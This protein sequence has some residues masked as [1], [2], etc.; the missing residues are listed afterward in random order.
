[1]YVRNL[2]RWLHKSKITSLFF[3]LDI[4]KA[5][6]SVKWDY[7]L[8]ILQ[9]RGFPC[10]FTDWI[11]TLLC[12]STSRIL[13]N[14]VVELP[15]SMVEAFAKGTPFPLLFKI[16]VDPLQQILELEHERCFFTRFAGGVP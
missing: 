3:K 8:D 11:M 7:I 5:F 13:L 15:S 16:A 6:D 2:D 12:T 14:G 9:W 4:H 1:M 10:K